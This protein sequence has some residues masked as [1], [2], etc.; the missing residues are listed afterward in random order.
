MRLGNL[1]HA[2]EEIRPSNRE[3][4]VKSK[5]QMKKSVD[6]TRQKMREAFSPEE[7]FKASVRA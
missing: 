3:I 5:D 7:K 1:L 2:E 6:D 4:E